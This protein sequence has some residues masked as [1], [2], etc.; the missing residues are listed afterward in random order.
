MNLLGMHMDKPDPGKDLIYENI[1][2]SYAPK[3][4]KKPEAFLLFTF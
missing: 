3:A 4:Y 2:G 1:T